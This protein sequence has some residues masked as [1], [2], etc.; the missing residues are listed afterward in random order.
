MRCVKLSQGKSEHFTPLQAEHQGLA[1]EIM[2]MLFD[3]TLSSEKVTY[4]VEVLADT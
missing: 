2:W 1:R 4:P 3:E